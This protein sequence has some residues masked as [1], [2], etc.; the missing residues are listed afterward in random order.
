M[1]THIGG[2]LYC[3]DCGGVLVSQKQLLNPNKEIT[4]DYCFSCGGYWCDHWEANDISYEDFL[5][6]SQ[7]LPVFLKDFPYGGG[8]KCPHCYIALD[9]L[10][11]ESIPVNLTVKF[12]SQCKGNWFPQGEFKNF[13]IAQKAKLDYLKTWHIPLN[14]IYQ[15]L[16]PI[17]IVLLVGIVLPLSVN[18]SQKKTEEKAAASTYLKNENVILSGSGE[19]IIIFNTTVAVPSEIEYGEDLDGM[20][21][22]TVSLTAATSHQIK[23]TGLKSNLTYTYRI[24]L[25]KDGAPYLLPFRNF[26]VK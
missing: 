1:S 14:S 2:G 15:V 23:L 11:A 16:L 6:L 18:L 8:G 10:R 7:K 3:P 12:C 20:N 19:A 5:K 13:K 17:F 4:I 24:I 26:K 21:K 9:T 25:H 22:V